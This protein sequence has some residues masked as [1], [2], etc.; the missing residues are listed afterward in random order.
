[1][2][3][4]RI[5]TCLGIIAFVFGTI[6]NTK[7]CTNFLVTKGATQDGSTMIT[8]A[9]DSHT[10]YGELYF[11]P[12]MNYPEGSM[13]DVIEW[14]TGKPM[15]KIKQA[16]H[17]YSVIGNMNENQVAIGETTYGGRPELYDTTAIVDYG[18]MMYIALQ[19]SKTAREAIKVMAELVAEYGYASEGESISI[20]DVN[21]VWIFEIIG[22]GSPSVDKNGK[23]VYDKGAVWVARRIPDGYISGHANQARITTFPFEKDKL[24]NSISS[25]NLNKIFDP[26]IENVYSY[27]VVTFARSKGYFK[28]EDKDFSFS[29]VY[30]PVNFEGA[31]FCEA[32]VWSGFNKVSKD[33]GKYVDYVKGDNLKNRMPLWIKPDY[34]LSLQHVIS[35]MRDHYEGTLFDMT[36]DVG[37]G[38]YGCGYRWRPLTWKVDG[39]T[40]VNERA[41]STQQTGFSFVAQSRP[42]MPDAIG[43]IFW[44]GVDDSYSTVYV[45]MYCGINRIPEPYR[46]GNGSMV[47]YSETSAFWIFNYVSNFCYLRYNYMIKDVQKVQRELEEKFRTEVP[48]IDKMALD[49]YKVSKEKAIEVINNYSNDQANLTAMSYKKL[50]QYLLVKYMDGNIKKEKDGKFLKNGYTQSASPNQPGYPVEYL[51]KIVDETGNRLLAPEEPKK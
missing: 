9:A 21:E 44:F 49:A 1:M 40:Y 34:K 33:M 31:R 27:D 24:K 3:K 14:D 2:K 36:Q 48:S 43:G 15:G 47:E 42:N 22:K 29:D 46:E 38:P 23:K 41:I 8:Y 51:K 26:R 30:A 6:F 17:T 10:L 18:S 11:R 20:S 19:R 4:L 32:R 39:K 16:R 5:I 50:G 25:K 28:G 7:A 35:L 45:P 12:A 37:A 13:M